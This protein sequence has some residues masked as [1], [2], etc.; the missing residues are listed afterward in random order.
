MTS[1]ADQSNKKTL[2]IMQ[3]L[4]LLDPRSFPAIA[5]NG[6]PK[7]LMEVLANSLRHFDANI[8]QTD[9]Q[10]ILIDLAKSWDVVKLWRLDGFD[11][12]H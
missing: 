7:E 3:D 4:S 1:F 6:Q 11:Y 12:Y 5:K 2:E 8:T 10:N 9:L